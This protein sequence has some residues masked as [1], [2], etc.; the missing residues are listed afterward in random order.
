MPAS[1]KI[2]PRSKDPIAK[3]VAAYLNAHFDGNLSAAAE[4]IGCPYD[5][6]RAQA[7]GLTM[8]P[9]LTVLQALAAHSGYT[10]DFWLGGAQ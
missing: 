6:L 4:A 5:S 3:R 7:L 8:R 10:I 1:Q 9:N 2:T